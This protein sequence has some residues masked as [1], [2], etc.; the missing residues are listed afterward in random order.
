MLASCVTIMAGIW[1]GYLPGLAIIA[2]L[3]VLAA[4]LALAG[5]IIDG[6]VGR[7]VPVYLRL[8][9]AA[10]LLIPGLLSAGMMLSNY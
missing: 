3:P 7:R 10:T 9:V 5:M 8:N 1:L 4:A 6:G 2:L